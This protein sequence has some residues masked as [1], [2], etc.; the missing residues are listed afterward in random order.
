MEKWILDLF[1]TI[2]VILVHF[3]SAFFIYFDGK[4]HFGPFS[5]HVYAPNCRL[6][7]SVAELFENMILTE[8][9]FSIISMNFN[10]VADL[11]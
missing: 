1:S 3:L 8:I 10:I 6:L 5:A 9:I 11:C 7:K 2:I 4:F